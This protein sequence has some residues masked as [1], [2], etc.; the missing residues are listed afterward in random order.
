LESHGKV[1]FTTVG[2]PGWSGN[3]SAGHSVNPR[4]HC[5]RAA[6]AGIRALRAITANC[7][8]SR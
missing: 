3:G 6:L 1:V 4:G 2:L 5:L 7:C 8:I